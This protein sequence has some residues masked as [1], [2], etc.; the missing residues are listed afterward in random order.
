MAFIAVL[1]FLLIGIGMII[2]EIFS[3]L[4]AVIPFVILLALGIGAAAV[5]GSKTQSRWLKAVIAI[6]VFVILY[7]TGT[8]GGS[9]RAAVLLSG[10]PLEAVSLQVRKAN[11]LELELEN[12]ESNDKAFLYHVTQNAPPS[13]DGEHTRDMWSVTRRGWLFY[14]AHHFGETDAYLARKALGVFQRAQDTRPVTVY[15]AYEDFTVHGFY[16]P[17]DTVVVLEILGEGRTGIVV[18]GKNA[19]GKPE[20]WEDVLL[21][22]ELPESTP[23]VIY[24]PWCYY[25]PLD[26]PEFRSEKNSGVSITPQLFAALDPSWSSDR[27]LSYQE[28]ETLVR[29]INAVIRTK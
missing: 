20:R 4:A 23:R 6:G 13:K 14:F 24:G 19:D 22:S 10:H 11:K 27:H 8:P 9:V 18:Y 15:R 25:L 5:L 21:N 17:K 7:A 12:W 28:I 16:V 26:T 1:A 29:Q 2:E 3:A